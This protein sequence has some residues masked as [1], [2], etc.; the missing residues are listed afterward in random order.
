MF[1]V[2][3]RRLCLKRP[4]HVV[5]S[6]IMRQQRLLIRITHPPNY[7]SIDHDP[8]LR[9]YALCQQITLVITALALS[10]RM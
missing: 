8:C 6:L 5:A 10:P 3:T 4:M 2:G 1:P 9:A 7:F